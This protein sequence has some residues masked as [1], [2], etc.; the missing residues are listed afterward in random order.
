[1]FCHTRWRNII[2]EVCRHIVG[3][4]GFI[5]KLCMK[6]QIYIWGKHS[7]WHDAD[8]VSHQVP[9]KRRLPGMRIGLRKCHGLPE[10]T[11]RT[12]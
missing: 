11:R 2:T 3:C 5:L 10:C 1:M 9:G 12:F 8:I 4:F 6:A 7:L